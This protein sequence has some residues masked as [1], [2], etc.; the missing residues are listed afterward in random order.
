MYG[1]G[2][3]LTV[4]ALSVVPRILATQYHNQLLET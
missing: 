1:L 2:L 4:V 3:A